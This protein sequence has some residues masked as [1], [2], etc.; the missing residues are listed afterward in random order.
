MPWSMSRAVSEYYSSPGFAAD[1]VDFLDPFGG[2]VN[3]AQACARF[4][5]ATVC[6]GYYPDSNFG[7]GQ[8]HREGLL[9]VSKHLASVKRGGIVWISPPR[10]SWLHLNQK[11]LG[12]MGCPE[13]DECP[14]IECE[15]NSLAT[16][17][18]N[19]LVAAHHW[20][21]WVVCEC[22]SGPL[23][24]HMQPI[25]EAL[26]GLHALDFPGQ[27]ETGHASSLSLKLIVGL[28]STCV[29]SHPRL[30]E[31]LWTSGGA[32]AGARQHYETYTGG[33]FGCLVQNKLR[34]ALCFPGPFRQVKC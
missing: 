1:T 26:T 7:I 27:V 29:R 28:L 30:E 24:A 6:S 4:F 23:V 33:G 16:F 13:Q 18:A 21:C 11:I 22:P 2:A 3:I 12:A 17:C 25:V 8:E 14:A 9:A 19:L 15:V 20:G 34:H 10:G 32:P 31:L 5:G